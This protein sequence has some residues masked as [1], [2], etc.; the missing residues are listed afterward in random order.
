MSD[1]LVSSNMALLNS[2]PTEALV[3]SV[4]IEAIDVRST[5]GTLGKSPEVGF[6][7]LSGIFGLEGEFTASIKGSLTVIAPEATAGEA[8]AAK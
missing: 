3:V 1:E 8:G 2:D 7:F 4:A 5:V 6:V